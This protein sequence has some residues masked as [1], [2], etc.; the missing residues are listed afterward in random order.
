MYGK[1]VLV[2]NDIGKQKKGQ[3][4]KRFFVE[5]YI[6]ERFHIYTGI[7]IGPFS[8]LL[9]YSKEPSRTILNS[10]MLQ[11]Q[12][13]QAEESLTSISYLKL[14]LNRGNV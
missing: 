1:N 6:R 10:L 2:K 7:D 8:I 11:R 12:C 13:H 4:L 14:N 9:Q 3:V 5:L